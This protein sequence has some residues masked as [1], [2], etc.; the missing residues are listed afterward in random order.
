MTVPLFLSAYNE[1]HTSA[2]I[3]MKVTRIIDKFRKVTFVC[4]DNDDNIKKALVDLGNIEVLTTGAEPAV[5]AEAENSLGHT[6]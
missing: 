1:Q 4:T 6:L 2:N 5:R 3:I